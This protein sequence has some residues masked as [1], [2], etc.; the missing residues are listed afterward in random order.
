MARG[1]IRRAPAAT[2]YGVGAGRK[3]GG[4]HAERGEGMPGISIHVV[5]VARGKA[6]VGM[7]IEVHAIDG[8]N[9]RV[10]ATGCVGESGTF[11]HPMN[12]GANVHKGVHEVLLHAGEYFRFVGQ[13]ADKPA[14][15]EIVPLRF[16]V[17]DVAD[18]YHLPVKITP[19]GFSVWR[20]A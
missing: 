7:F 4:G 10:I 15:Q 16:H 14:F 17:L 11:D 20:G 12:T 2:G 18:H 19:W 1:R 8:D 6:A 3:H 5:D 13:I 9:R